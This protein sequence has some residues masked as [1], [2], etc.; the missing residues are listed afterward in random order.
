MNVVKEVV[1]G[2]KRLHAD[3]VEVLDDDERAELK[4]AEKDAV[5]LCVRL[6]WVRWRLRQL[7]WGK[8][9]RYVVMLGLGA[10]SRIEL[11]LV[12]SRRKSS[13]ETLRKMRSVRKTDA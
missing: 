8:R 6:L 12:A 10:V 3:F 13:R 7:G 9:E 5:M 1:D 4:A 2:V 11:S